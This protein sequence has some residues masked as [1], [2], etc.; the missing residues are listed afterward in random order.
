MALSSDSRAVNSSIAGYRREIAALQVE[1]CPPRAIKLTMGMLCQ[2]LIAVPQLGNRNLERRVKG[3]V[4]Q[5]QAGREIH[6][7]HVAM[8]DPSF[9]VI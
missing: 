5:G 7:N 2:G 3:P 4:H 8:P 6:S 1:Q 9:W